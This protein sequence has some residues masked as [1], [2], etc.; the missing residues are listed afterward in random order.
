MWPSWRPAHAAS[1]CAEPSSHRNAEDLEGTEPKWEFP[2]LC[3][4]GGKSLTYPGVDPRPIDGTPMASA[5][6]KAQGEIAWMDGLKTGAPDRGAIMQ[7]AVWLVRARNFEPR[8]RACSQ[9]ELDRRP[10]RVT[11]DP[12]KGDPGGE[13]PPTPR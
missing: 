4:G 9:E 5:K 1:R 11:G 7:D 8:L 12:A 10:L 6:H 2:R 3:R 13:A